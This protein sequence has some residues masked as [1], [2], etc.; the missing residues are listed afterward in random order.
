MKKHTD[1]LNEMK[2]GKE[3]FRHFVGPWLYGKNVAVYGNDMHRTIVAETTGFKP[4]SK[5]L[6]ITPEQYQ[7]L[8]SEW[9]DNG[10]LDDG[11]AVVTQRALKFFDI[12]I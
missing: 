6:R 4:I 8:R 7:D 1:F 9:T 10:S 5:T 12:E 11:D 3:S 2:A